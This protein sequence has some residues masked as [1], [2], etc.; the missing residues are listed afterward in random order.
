MPH[1][2]ESIVPEQ[3]G[4]TI[5]SPGIEAGAPLPSAAIPAECEGYRHGSPAS[6]GAANYLTGSLLV[7]DP[8]PPSAKGSGEGKWNGGAIRPIPG[9]LG[10][11]ASIRAELEG[12]YLPSGSE[13]QEGLPRG[14]EGQD[15]G[16]PGSASVPPGVQVVQPRFD[17]SPGHRL[18]EYRGYRRG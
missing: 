9:P 5:A 2:H 8:G 14:R 12:C 17:N 11:D 4:S 1:V 13:A 3:A 15:F 7:L 16:A 10:E 18:F 6:Q